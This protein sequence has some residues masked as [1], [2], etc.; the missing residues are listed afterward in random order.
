MLGDR[1]RETRER[2]GL[3]MSN[4]ARRAQMT[5]AQLSQIEHNKTNGS[6][7]TVARIASALD[8]P[9]FTLF[10]ESDPVPGIVRKGDR[11]R[12]RYPGSDAELEFITP[13]LNRPL[14]LLETTL[15]PGMRGTASAMA[16]DGDES[17][18]V[19]DGEVTL[20]IGDDRI[21]L[22]AG[23]AYTFDAAIPHSLLNE[24]RTSCTLLVALVGGT[25]TVPGNGDKPIHLNGGDGDAQSLEDRGE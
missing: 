2:R 4:L 20:V 16:H 18:L 5:K 15:A 24:G 17:V 14:I 25:S 23:D 11:A 1:I 22:A 19:Q 8:V 13:V 12:L 10:I 3:S 21:V 7:Q 9:L 6:V